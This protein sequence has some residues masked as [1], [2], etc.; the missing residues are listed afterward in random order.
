[1]EEQLTTACCSSLPSSS[2]SSPRTSGSPKRFSAARF[3]LSS[4]SSSDFFS[5]SRLVSKMSLESKFSAFAV[6]LLL[7]FPFLKNEI[8]KSWLIHK[9]KL[10]LGAWK[11]KVWWMGGELS[12][13]V[14]RRALKAVCETTSRAFAQIQTNHCRTNSICQNSEKNATFAFNE[15]LY[16]M[17]NIVYGDFTFASLSL[18][19]LW[20]CPHLLPAL[21]RKNSREGFEPEWLMMSDQF[22]RRP[23]KY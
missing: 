20:D 13:A 19:L 1:M 4:S 11:E 14:T 17:E 22:K 5:L 7:F 9:L 18:Q 15:W 10:Y 8:H 12:M 3:S 21:Q 2:S 16:P 6:A 23:G